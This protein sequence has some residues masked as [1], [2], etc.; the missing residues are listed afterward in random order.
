MISVWFLVSRGERENW[1]TPERRGRRFV[2]NWPHRLSTYICQHTLHKKGM[3]IYFVP[4]NFFISFHKA[5]CYTCFQFPVT[6]FMIANVCSPT[7]PT[8]RNVSLGG[9]NRRVRKLLLWKLPPPPLYPYFKSY[10]A[11]ETFHFYLVM[12]N[13]LRVMAPT[14]EFLDSL[15]KRFPVNS[16]IFREDEP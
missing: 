6:P 7:L 5:V 14:R 3:Q 8:R 15:I 10:R 12:E 9:G 13:F 11:T 1:F 16:F 2:L 4:W